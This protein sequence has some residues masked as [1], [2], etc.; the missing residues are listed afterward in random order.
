MKCPKCGTENADTNLFC[1]LCGT[2]LA[3]ADT[4]PPAANVDEGIRGIIVRRFDAI[5]N[6]D[7]AAVTALM[8]E[9]Y[10]KFDDWAPYQSQER[11]EALQNEFSAF[12]VM[13]NYNYDLKDLKTKVLGDAAIATFTVHYT[14]NMR[15]QQF[16]V[17]SRVTTVMKKQDSTWKIIHEHLSR[18]PSSNPSN[19]QQ[20]QRRRGF[21]FPF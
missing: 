14:T 13:S 15:N 9:G 7:E 6:R 18:Y 2:K 4:S 20:P 3:V 10:S 5:K 17:T 21:G 8:D 1:N 11:S 12:K 19:Q 16:D